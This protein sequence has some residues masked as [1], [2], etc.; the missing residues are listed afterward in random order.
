[1]HRK[2]SHLARLRSS[3]HVHRLIN[4]GGGERSWP[5]HRATPRPTSWGAHREAVC[6]VFPVHRAG[7]PVASRDN[8]ALGKAVA[9]VCGRSGGKMLGTAR[10]RG[11]QVGLDPPSLP[12][13]LHGLCECSWRCPQ[14]IRWPRT[15]ALPKVPY[16][17]GQSEQPT[18]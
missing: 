14:C 11:P 6:R 10:G 16:L 9:G 18:A 4:R 13:Q 15:I 7:R 17:A 8:C 12:L 2:P 3:A 5:R 1:M